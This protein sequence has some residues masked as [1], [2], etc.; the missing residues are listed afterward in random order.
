M[1]KILLF[2]VCW[3]VAATAVQA[4]SQTQ[5]STSIV[6][7][8]GES[9]Y[10]HTVKQGDTFYSLCK[11]YDTDEAAIRSSNPHVADGLQTDQV[12]KI[13]VV[14]ASEKPLSDRK[15][16]RLFDIHTVNQGETA[17]SIAK[18]YG[19]G[20]DVLMEDNEGFDPAHLSIGQQI[21]IRKASQG[22]S[23]TEEIEEQI[24]SYKDALNSVSDR[25]THHVVEKGE[26]LYSLGKR[27]GLPVDS[28]ATYNEPI[29]KDGLKEGSILRVPIPQQETAPGD[30]PAPDSLR[31][32]PGQYRPME[33]ATVRPVDVTGTIKVAVLL[34]LKGA[35]VSG[36]QFLEFYQGALLALE[37][38]KASGISVKVDL[39]NTGKSA[40]ETAEILQQPELQD[41]NLIIGPVYDECFPPVTAF[42]AQHG[43]PVVSPLAVVESADSPLLFQ[44][45][46][47][48]SVKNDKL[49]SELAGDKNVIVISAAANDS[50]FAA[51]IQSLIPQGAHRFNYTK[52][53]GGAALEGLLSGEKDNV[54]V[55]LASDETSIDGILAYVG[56]VQNSLTSRSIK[57]PAIRVIGSS[58]WARLQNIERNLFFKLNLRYVT[59]YHAD[60]GNERVLNFDRRY[61][62]AF[63]SLP[64]LY[65][66][67]G[68]DIAKLFIGGL[69]MH[70]AD[71]ASFLNNA[72][73]P[74]LQTPY[75]FVRKS[76]EHKYENDQ[77]ALVCYNNNYTI[78]VK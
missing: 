67:R 69:K 22:K 8:G 58:R 56:S 39:F 1:K 17:Y 59:S 38:L 42:A 65:A 55:V 35:G 13:P 57:N 73:L 11:V 32:Y 28:I 4:Q 78:E 60:R 70:G 62:S 24:E 36:R 31:L 71:F 9:Y 30:R 48:P 54:I 44:A 5:K 14:K 2:I 34:P 76:P 15:K 66:Y 10:V 53:M 52:G 33:H 72:E 23:D 40:A 25:F 3:M 77:W 41:A 7:I 74:L 64:S 68:Y 26:T 50:E 43:I 12:I 47:E 46:P 51:E 27:F 6:T 63:N 49:R 45:A 16:K 61:V 37:E 29:L 75:R 18:R 20:L 21:N 19:V